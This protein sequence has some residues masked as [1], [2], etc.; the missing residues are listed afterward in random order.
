M[1]AARHQQA[2]REPQPQQQPIHGRTMARDPFC[3][4]H[5]RARQ[6]QRAVGEPRG[7]QAVVR[8]RARPAHDVAEEQRRPQQVRIQ[9]LVVELD[10]QREQRERQGGG[11][12]RE[13]QGEQHRGDEFDG[14]TRI[15]GRDRV[16]PGDRVLVARERERVVPVGRLEQAGDEEALGEPQANVQIEQRADDP[17]QC[18]HRPGI[19]RERAAQSARGQARRRFLQGDCRVHRACL[20]PPAHATRPA[21]GAS[22]AGSACARSRQ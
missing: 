2:G 18:R 3:R 21:A 14:D 11:A 5:G 16:H 4:A 15:G 9:R 13:P 1:K 7:E 12:G 22:A 8:E 20:H 17:A 6:R 19:G 10:H